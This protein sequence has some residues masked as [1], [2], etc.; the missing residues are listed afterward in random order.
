MC[1]SG[2]PAQP[3]FRFEGGMLHIDSG[4][5]GRVTVDTRGI[6]ASAL[7][8]VTDLLAD[9]TA[10]EAHIGALGHPVSPSRMLP[11]RQQPMRRPSPEL[12]SLLRTLHQAAQTTHCMATDLAGLDLLA[13]V[14]AR[15]RR[16]RINQTLL[17]EL[18]AAVDAVL[19]LPAKVA[20]R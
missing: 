11:A 14:T 2:E 20:G 4:P 15:V 3:S 1:I 13:A 18:D 8:P 19:P 6:V 17:D 9:M 12:A 5:H 10:L 7:E 16:D